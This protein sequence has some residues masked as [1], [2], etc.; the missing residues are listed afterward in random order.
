MVPSMNRRKFLIRS[1]AAS[2]SASVLSKPLLASAVDAAAAP[3]VTLLVVDT[4]RISIPIDDRIYGHFLEH[5]NHSVVD[6]LFAEQIR[7]CGFEG[8]DFKSYWEPFSDGGRVEIA[9]VEFQNGK[10]SVRLHAEDGRAG[11]RQGRLFVDARQE[12]DGSLWIKRE[13]GSPQMMLRVVSSKG[14]PIASVPLA[15]TGSDWQEV[16]YSFTSPV[17]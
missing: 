3:R 17:R 7:G 10:K 2:A 4:D 14:D 9:E 16:R 11:I 5:I 12:Y 1:M 15:L 8:E 6:G 13:Q